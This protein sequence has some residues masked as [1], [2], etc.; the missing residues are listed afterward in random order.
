M[1]NKPIGWAAAVLLVAASHAVFAEDYDGSKPLICA[2]V[3]ANGCEPDQAVM[4]GMIDGPHAR[5]KGLRD[6]IYK[7]GLDPTPVPD[8]TMS[9]VAMSEAIGETTEVEKLQEV[10][11]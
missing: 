2:T 3:E 9:L 11:K 7:R 5:N 1:N 4:I 6:L 8:T 10:P